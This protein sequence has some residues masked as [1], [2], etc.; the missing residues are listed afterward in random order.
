M[1]RLSHPILGLLSAVIVLSVAST[2]Y[3][4]V[5]HSRVA[6]PAGSEENA[7]PADDLPFTMDVPE[8]WTETRYEEED[9]VEGVRTYA[10]IEGEAVIF[11]RDVMKNGKNFD[12]VAAEFV[13]DETDADAIAALMVAEA[14][15][16]FPNFSKQD[17]R[18]SSVD[19]TIGGLA[20][21]HSTLQCLKPCYVE[22]GA[23]TTV[24]YIVDAPDRVYILQVELGMS[25]S[26]SARLNAADA[27]VRTFQ[28]R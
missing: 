7:V 22:D 8:G 17:V 9:R 3:F 21:V 13:W 23:S 1:I 2:G 20:A 4:I 26:A 11:V 14:S 6:P 25:A 10:K 12:E 5:T 15:E 16:L 27:V 28:I 24:R 18:V 19:D